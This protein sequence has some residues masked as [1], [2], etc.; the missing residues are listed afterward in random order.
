MTPSGYRFRST[1]L[2]LLL[3]FGLAWTVSDPLGA[4]PANPPLVVTGTL[5]DERGV[6][7]AGVEVL[8]RPYPSDYAQQLF[9]LGVAE[10]LPNAVDAV[11]SRLDGV[12]RLTAAAA[13]PYRLEL[14]PRLLARDTEAAAPAVYHALLPLAAPVVLAPIE[15][16][17]LH[18][19]TVAVADEEGQPIEA[20]LVVATPQ[21]P[22]PTIGNRLGPR[23][24]PPP[25]LY[26]TFEAAAARTGADGMA[27][28]HMPHHRTRLLVSAPGFA[29]AERR[30][31]VG[32]ANFHLEPDPG[33]VFLASDPTGEP[34]PGAVVRTGVDRATPLALTDESGSATL[35]V[36][37]RRPTM[38]S[39][40]TSGHAIGQTTPIR[41]FSPADAPTERTVAVRLVAPD[42]VRGQVIDASTGLPIP[43]AAVWVEGE[44][45]RRE[46]TDPSGTF[47]L[48]VRSDKDQGQIQVTAAGYAPTWVNA[49]ATVQ[50][51]SSSTPIGLV[52]AAPLFGW[53]VDDAGEPVAGADVR[54]E[55]GGWP[56]STR[57]ASGFDGG[58]WIPAASYD[59]PYRLHVS[60]PGFARVTKDVPPLLPGSTEEPRY[61]V[62]AKGRPGRGRVVDTG[63]RPIPYATV[64]LRM[65]RTINE[66]GWWDN[67]DFETATTDIRGE[68]E[69]QAVGVGRY[70][71]KASHPDHVPS[72]HTTV[73]VA[74]TVGEAHL[75]TLTLRPGLKLHG[76]VRDSKGEPVASAN[77]AAAW[78]EPSIGEQGL[79]ETTDANGR[80]EFRGLGTEPVD[81]LV[82]AES[83]PPQLE[84]DLQPGRDEP[85][86]IELDAGSA[87][88]GGR[89]VDPNGNPV[90]AAP[91][92]AYCL[93][94]APS[95][96][97]YL[98]AREACIRSTTTN[99]GGRFEFDVLSPGRWSIGVQDP[100]DQ[101]MRG[102]IESVELG[103]DDSTEVE[104]RLRAADRLIVTVTNPQGAPVPDALVNAAGASP[105]ALGSTDA[106][107]RATLF[108]NLESAL[109]TGVFAG[110]SDYVDQVQLVELQPGVN[111]VHLELDAGWEMT[112]YVRSR[113]GFSLAMAT[114]EA[115]PQDH[116][117]DFDEGEVIRQWASPARTTS[118]R[119][120]WFRLPGLARGR[121]SVKARLGGYAEGGLAAPVEIDGRSV[122]GVEIQLKAV[123]PE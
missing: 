48:A 5:V 34:A 91:V 92:D 20:A 118:D 43:D 42:R 88:L 95:R 19:L 69:F 109:T 64:Q 72:T 46:P 85:V 3:L 73:D 1:R 8:L 106:T 2:R 9:L 13:G 53:I 82:T 7:A 16:P 99:S 108:M 68:F 33:L 21:S 63:S 116:L 35:S 37:T 41:R 66:T 112:G 15:V 105:T 113:D 58:F 75:G 11:R 97:L 62:L 84:E 67:H 27:R 39:V 50:D 89:V 83:Y 38:F 79:Q 65:P 22:R 123:S 111:E 17:D 80:F 59:V 114:V 14:R 57:A 100:A 6:P 87:S 119:N 117:S 90:A 18:P 45:G 52:P 71:I 10:A 51:D 103:I 78:W 40:E 31:G 4:Q 60:A 23:D 104:V 81:L 55:A 56:P 29:L 101:G 12:F 44:P 70:L 36:S 122:G 121:Y 49:S 98:D 76:T 107:G 110:H 74:A 93:D 25:L 32:K 26:P 94:L 61:I 28:F 115:T 120:G 47:E 77:V 30:A 96:L 54:A 24:L 86:S 102:K